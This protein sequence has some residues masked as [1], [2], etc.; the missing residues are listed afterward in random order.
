MNEEL[1]KKQIDAITNQ[2][3]RLEALTNKDDHKSLCKE[4][5][6]KIVKEKFDGIKELTYKIDHNDLIYFKNNTVEKFLMILI[7]V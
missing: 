3:K 1:R 2:N 5:F 6:D 4:I 7:M